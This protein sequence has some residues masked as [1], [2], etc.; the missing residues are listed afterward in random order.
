MFFVVA[1]ATQP[2]DIERTIVV[3]VMTVAGR[4]ATP[5][6][7]LLLEVAVLHGIRDLLTCSLVRRPFLARS[8]PV[9]H[10]VR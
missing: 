5:L 3:L 7:W 9:P 4:I 8:A 10:V 2:H 1:T 6:T